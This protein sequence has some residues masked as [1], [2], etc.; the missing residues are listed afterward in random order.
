MIATSG[1]PP[2]ANPLLL[3]HEAAERQV[4]QWITR[5]RLPHALF[6]CGPWGIG[7]AT[8]AFR[9][10]R[11]LLRHT[12]HEHEL[13]ELSPGQQAR[14]VKDEPE[15]ESSDEIDRWITSGTHPDLLTVEKGFD[16]KKE[17]ARSE[18]I[19]DDVRKIGSFLASSPAM[20]GWR[21]VIIDSADEMNRNAANALLKVLEEPGHKSLII[22]VAHQPGLVPATIRSRC[23]KLQLRP[24]SHST[25]TQLIAQFVPD[26]SVEDAALLRE[27]AEGS[28]G[29]V[30]QLVNHDGVKVCRWFRTFFQALSNGDEQASLV[31]IANSGLG[32]DQ[33]GFRVASHILFS[34]LRRIARVSL[35][36]SSTSLSST[37]ALREEEITVDRL[38]AAAALDRWLKVWD[39]TYHLAAQADAGNLDRKQVFTT[40]LLY[41]QRELQRAPS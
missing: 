17:R 27:L 39:K 36:G 8:M 35:S 25:L 3:G 37:S 22:L 33:A 18:I 10:S 31:S 13:F 38:A 30:L 7:K 24:L 29:R 21:I 14:T 9:I 26:L 32:L 34:W 23:R 2:R 15:A 6:I 5:G 40:I 4:E 11:R 19:I 1:I 16:E 12:R 28:I 41:V 20:G